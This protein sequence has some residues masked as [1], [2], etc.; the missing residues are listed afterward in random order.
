MS[1]TIERE[2]LTEAEAAQYLALAPL[3][4]AA[5]R[6][7]GLSPPYLRLPSLGAGPARGVRYRRSDV[8]SFV[9][10]ALEHAGREIA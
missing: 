9:T 8:E 7:R 6:R 4:L 5:L 3:T 10:A 1:E 2:L